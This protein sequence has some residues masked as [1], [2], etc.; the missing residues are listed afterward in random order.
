MAYVKQEW[1]DEVINGSAPVYR[2]T[3]ADGSVVA[4]NVS[5]EL[6]TQ[7]IQAGTQVTAE[8]MNHIED[9]IAGITPASIGALPERPIVI[10]M[11]GA[12]WTGG[13]FDFH[14]GGTEED[15]TTRVGEFARGTFGVTGNLTVSEYISSKNINDSGWLE[16][17][18]ANGWARVPNG[19][20]RFRK[21]NNVVYVIGQLSGTAATSPAF[22]QLPSGF[23]PHVQMVYPCVRDGNTP[24]AGLVGSDGIMWFTTTA[25]GNIMHFSGSWIGEV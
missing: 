15:F 5:I 12:S 24:V 21:Y 16:M 23:R 10:E 13:F 1:K 6:V 8:R 11:G 18:L 7:I 19:L 4:D 9:G 20:A 25:Y 22:I 17:G 14:F 2:L 3:R